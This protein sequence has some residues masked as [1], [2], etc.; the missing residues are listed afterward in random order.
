MHL[1]KKCT[2]DDYCN[3]Y[4]VHIQCRC[5]HCIIS[6][7]KMLKVQVFAPS[8]LASFGNQKLRPSF[9]ILFIH[10][11]SIAAIQHLIILSFAVKWIHFDLYFCRRTTAHRHQIKLSVN[12]K[13]IKNKNTPILANR[14]S[15]QPSLWD[16]LTF[17]SINYTTFRCFK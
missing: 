4:L 3:I 17:S 12:L 16:T 6:C 2:W 10:K 9:Y 15:H 14:I 7:W 5:D 13:K 8:T 1:K 11:W